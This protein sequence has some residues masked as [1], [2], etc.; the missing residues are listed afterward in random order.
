MQ[1]EAVI[2]YIAEARGWLELAAHTTDSRLHVKCHNPEKKRLVHK[3]FL[4]PLL[5][6]CSRSGTANGLL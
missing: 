2:D 4:N 6:I 5:A 3:A 1:T